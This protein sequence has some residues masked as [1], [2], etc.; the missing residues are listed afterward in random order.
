MTVVLGFAGVHPVGDAAP[1]DVT[2]H[3]GTH[4]MAHLFGTVLLLVVMTHSGH[5]RMTGFPSA[6]NGIPAGQSSDAEHGGAHHIPST[7]ST[8][9]GRSPGR[10]SANIGF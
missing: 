10:Q 5:T 1:E 2:T 7:P 3:A 9:S 4:T 8:V 6:V